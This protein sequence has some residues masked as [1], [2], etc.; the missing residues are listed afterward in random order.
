MKDELHVL[1]YFSELAAT[2]HLQVVDMTRYFVEN[3]QQ[4]LE[5]RKEER[6]QLLCA[7]KEAGLAYD[8]QCYYEFVFPDSEDYESGSDGES[9]E[10]DEEA[11]G[12][13]F[14]VF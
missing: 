1:T 2:L 5:A 9:D 12:M 14:R 13:F 7:L 4:I 8:P 11:H 3:E 6:L 10:E